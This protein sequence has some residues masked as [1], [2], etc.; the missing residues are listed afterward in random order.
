MSSSLFK[1]HLA[2][3]IYIFI[4]KMSKR[5]YI[6]ADKISCRLHCCRHGTKGYTG[7]KGNSNATKKKKIIIIIIGFNLK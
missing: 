6:P 7:L 4:K 3:Y 2:V 1:V 5:C